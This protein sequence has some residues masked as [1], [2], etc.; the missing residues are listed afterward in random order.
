MKSKI[1]YT[2]F[3]L[4]GF[5]FLFT[6][7][8]A[9]PAEV[10]GVDRTGSPL[11][12][13]ACVACHSAGEFSPSITVDV[14]DNGSSVNTYVPGQSYTLRV[15]A[16]HGSGMP[17]GF[18]FQAVALK[19]TDD[20][21]AGSFESAPSSIQF[22]ELSGRQYAEQSSPSNNNT[23][24][25]EWVAPEAGTGDVNIYSAIVVA[26]GANGSGGDGAAF[27][28]NPLVLSETLVSTKSVD[29]LLEQMDIYPNPVANELRLSLNSETSGNYDLR[30]MNMQGQ[31]A[32]AESLSLISG[33]QHRTV[34]VSQLAA[35][36][37]TV[38]ISDGNKS[39]TRRLVK[40]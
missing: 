8:A 22:V 33:A 40:K 9:G 6:N 36:V 1:V 32:Y 18:G 14:L 34:D 24:E 7:N 27:L 23:F 35:G 10:Q 5:A 17:A 25:V 28:N 2:L 19:A 20:S 13:A 29:G 15:I 16:G 39:S 4:A 38:I 21:Q 26:D 12:P 37:Y 11:S 3:A 30:I 31:T